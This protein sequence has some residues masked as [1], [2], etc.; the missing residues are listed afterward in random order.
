M[1]YAA[2]NVV[3]VDRTAVDDRLVKRDEI[4][5]SHP[6][7]KIQDA[8]SMDHANLGSANPV[9][10]NLKTLLGMFSEGQHSREPI[11]PISANTR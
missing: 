11:P 6:A 9:D 1:E 10:R 2:F 5:S 3:Y 8:N 4:I 7:I